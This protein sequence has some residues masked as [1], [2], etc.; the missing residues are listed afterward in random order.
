SDFLT[1]RA[2]CASRQGA[3][4][5]ESADRRRDFAS[6]VR[7]TRLQ[8][9]F[10]RGLLALELHCGRSLGGIPVVT[11]VILESALEVDDHGGRSRLERGGRRVHGDRSVHRFAAHTGTLAIVDTFRLALAGRLDNSHGDAVSKRAWVLT[12]ES[13]IHRGCLATV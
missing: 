3:H 9:G 1:V 8:A 2:E 4:L 6:P 5:R 7:P 13:N 11:E 10:W 12:R